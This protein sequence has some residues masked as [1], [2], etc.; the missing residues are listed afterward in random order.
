[1]RAP[2][3]RVL[4]V[5]VGNAARGDDGLG[6]QLMQRLRGSAH[7]EHWWLTLIEDAQLQIEH[8][9]D[10]QISDLALFVDASADAPAPC[11]LREISAPAGHRIMPMSHALAPEDVLHTLVTIGRRAAPP[12]FLLAIRGE[13]FELGQALSASAAAHLDAASRLVDELLRQ[14]EAGAWRARAAPA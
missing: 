5:G 8:A 6:P 11:T 4:V 9:L 14:P 1:M 3:T 7:G 13:R 2:Q 12:S 10:L